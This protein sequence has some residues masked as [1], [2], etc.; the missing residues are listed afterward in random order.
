M[1]RLSA[2]PPSAA[3]GKF[4]RGDQLSSNPL[5]VGATDLS[6]RGNQ[7]SPL[8]PFISAIAQYEEV[9]TDR[10]HVAIVACLLGRRCH[11]WPT[12]TPLLADLFASSIA[13]YFPEAV[14][15]GPLPSPGS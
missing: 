10:V 4:F 8:E 11:V 14:F 9:H 15:H 2:P 7:H 12:V 13:P 5:H 1:G 6:S 3:I